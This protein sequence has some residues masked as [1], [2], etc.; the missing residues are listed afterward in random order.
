MDMHAYEHFD[1]NPDMWKRW[2]QVYDLKKFKADQ[3]I[4]DMY[5]SDDDDENQNHN[6]K[7]NLKA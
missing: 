3:R 7:N 6:N 4:L 1:D 5:F 2:D